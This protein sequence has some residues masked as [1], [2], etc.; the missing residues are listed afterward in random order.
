MERVFLFRYDTQIKVSQV[1]PFASSQVLH[2]SIFKIFNIT[3]AIKFQKLQ[4]HTFFGIF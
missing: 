2:L 4:W 3:I 1:G